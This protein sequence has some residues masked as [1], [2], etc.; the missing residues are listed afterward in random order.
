MCKI[1]KEIDAPEKEQVIGRL[2]DHLKKHKNL[3][4]FADDGVIWGFMDGDKLVT[5]HQIDAKASPELREK[6]LQQAFIF[7]EKEEVRLFHDELNQWHARLVV[8]GSE[9]IEESQILWGDEIIGESQHGFIQVKD[10]TKGIPNQ[11]LPVGKGT[12]FRL[13][14]HHNITYNE[15]GEAYVAFSRMAGLRIGNR[16]EEV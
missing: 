15:N 1:T 10:N 6:T 5:S 13:D 7:D 2:T 3:L 9:V 8:D 12:C 4:A 16:K 11:Y 14:F